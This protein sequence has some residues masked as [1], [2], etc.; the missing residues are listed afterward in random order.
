MKKIL[1]GSRKGLVEFTSVDD[2]DFHWLQQYPWHRLKEYV[3][4]GVRPNGKRSKPITVLMHRLIMGFVD[5]NGKELVVGEVD[6][7]DRDGFNN[8]RLNLRT[9]TRSQNCINKGVMAGSSKYKGVSKV[10][11]G[12]WQ[13]RL[14]NGGVSEYLGLSD[15]EEEAARV[16][17]KRARELYGE[18][19]CLNFPV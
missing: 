17:D 7:R 18:F 6:H 11:S 3:A 19:S 12:R 9:S 8:Q 4:T 5:I 16:Y 2:G 1:L 10:A 15:T 14:S 13:A